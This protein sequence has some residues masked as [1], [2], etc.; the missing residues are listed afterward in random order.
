MALK[1]SRTRGW[2]LVKNNYDDKDFTHLYNHKWKTKYVVI[3]FE[4]GEKEKTPHL[5][6]Y[7][8]WDAAKSFSSMKKEFY[9]WHI[10]AAVSSAEK[11]REYCIKEG[12]FFEKGEMPK[13]G[14]RTD[15]EEIAEA[16]DD[17]ADM[18]DISRMWKSQYIRYHRGIEKYRAIGFGDRTEPPTVLW[19][20]GE[21]GSGKT[22]EAT[23]SASFYMKDGTHWWDGYEQQ[24]TIVIDDFDGRWPFRDLL[25]LLDRYPYQGQYKGG[26]VKINSSQIIITCEYPPEHFWV[27]TELAQ[28]LRRITQVK[29]F[30]TGTEVSGNTMPTQEKKV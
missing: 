2:S 11:N 7:V 19:Y 10:E 14:K 3:G 29:K 9:S 17:G 4:E 12:K 5:Q 25:R 22:R 30:G 27:H 15:L 6:C 16:I 23:S 26:Y 8:Y 18:Y 20:W 1:E 24:E 21:S 13:Q 28:I